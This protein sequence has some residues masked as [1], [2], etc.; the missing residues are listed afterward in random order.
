VTARPVSG[1]HPSAPPSANASPAT[2][3][4]AP[5]PPDGSGRLR[6]GAGR[7]VAR[8][9]PADRWPADLPRK[10]AR[11]VIAVV[12]AGI[13]CA[14]LSRYAS[15]TLSG[16]IDVVGNPIAANFDYLRAFWSYRLAT[17]AFSFL[18]IVFYVLLVRFG[19]LRRGS[20]PAGHGPIALTDPERAD[21][22]RADSE[23]AHPQ[24]A[25][26]EPTEDATA[27]GAAPRPGFGIVARLGLPAAI[28]VD[29][30]GSRNGHTGLVAVGCGLVY[31]AVVVAGA[32]LWTRR[33]TRAGGWSWPGYWRRLALVNGVAA[34]IGALL[35]LWFVSAHTVVVSGS[36][37]Q[38]WSWLPWWVVLLGVAAVIG[39]TLRQLRRGRAAD[40][41]ERTLVAVV[42]GS[43][44]LF[45]ATSA[46]PGPVEHFQ[47]F[48]D[49]LQMAGASLLNRGYFPWRDLLPTHGVYLDIF[50]GSIGQAVFGSTV[51]GISA[52]DSVVLIPLSWVAVYLFVAW[53]TRS[54]GW[55][56]ALF[57]ISV[58]V[59]FLPPM[60]GSRFMLVP[61]TFVV[62]GETLR[63]QSRA[64]CVGL[65]LLLFGQVILVPETSFLAAPAFAVL[66]AADLLHRAGR[67]WWSALRLTRWAV[68]TGAVALAVFI[69]FLAVFHAVGAFIDYY[70]VFGPGH[71]EAGAIRPTG[72]TYREYLMLAA[73]V[74]AVLLTVWV[75]AARLG[76]RGDWTPVDWVTVAAAGLVALYTE[77]ALGRFDSPHVWQVFGVALPLVLLWAWRLLSTAGR[78]VDRLFAVD[79]QRSGHWSW[80][81]WAD[82]VTAVAVAALLL[83]YVHPFLDS[84]RGIDNRHLMTATADPGFPGLGYAVPGAIDT[85]MLADLGTTLRAYAGT[86]QPVFDMTNSLGWVY[87]LLARDPGTRFAHVNG[88]IPPYAQQ[89]LISDLQRSRPPVVIFD[90]TSMGMPSWDYLNNNV[91]HYEI[92][93]YLL[94]GWV[95]VLRTHGNLILV[96]RDL[97]VPGLPV[98]ALATP[99]QTADLWFT[100][101]ACY[102][103]YSPVFLQSA[104]TGR[105]TRV[106]VT[107]LGERTIASLSGWAVDPVTKGPAHTVVV[108][109]GNRAIASVTPTL[110]RPDVAKAIGVPASVS[111]FEFGGFVAPNEKLSAYV[112][113]DDG[114]LYPLVD[115][116]S[117]GAAS[118]Q[119]ADG[120][121]AAV[122]SSTATVGVLESNTAERATV[123]QFTVPAGTT[124]GDY[125]LATLA[126][127]AGALGQT[128]FVLTDAPGQPAHSILASSLPAAGDRLAIRV[129]SCLQ[130]R[131]Y[132]PTQ[133]VYVV[134]SSGPAVTSVTLSDVRN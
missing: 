13:V 37:R 120:R 125:H 24:R 61:L 22:A 46:L 123:G 50:T 14:G 133:P 71:N 55:F 96:R 79:R 124:L 41:I 93:Q 67:S 113:A 129:G 104:A 89:L 56:L 99:P 91:H 121:V 38:T 23:R 92:S 64:W 116:T 1:E 57:G 16:P 7:S 35:S 68:A 15:P 17:Y 25:D 6:D 8:W 65:T 69:A 2:N 40:R 43:V 110:D 102:W 73:C 132:Q 130:W 66:V 117:G 34:G 54:N 82:A 101:G 20:A 86:D 36:V 88:A 122:A 81:S 26:S 109:S 100:G 49:A 48:D 70:L 21:S 128:D 58:A 131:G 30:V 97:V 72:I 62:L 105:S 19:P 4:A 28:V 111:G 45:L 80:P 29:A 47:G 32:G 118:I 77:K 90:S 12:V 63:R 5:G 42:A 78:Q 112:L 11:F 134:Q 39:W 60:I 18:S 83:G 119:L 98:P 127:A 27:G 87:F 53:V 75:T 85:G 95:P 103:G 33:G 126:S 107:T 108:A 59:G 51:W 114:K 31:L 3:H 9:W 44:A 76:R 106:P 52:I 10:A 94:D 84:V 74:L 115:S